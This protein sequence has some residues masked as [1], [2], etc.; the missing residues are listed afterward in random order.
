[1]TDD[2]KTFRKSD[3]WPMVATMLSATLVAAGIIA[4]D[5]VF[6]SLD[7]GTVRVAIIGALVLVAALALG[8]IDRS[9]AMRR[10]NLFR[11]SATPE[12]SA[13]WAAKLQEEI[14]AQSGLNPENSDRAKEAMSKVP[15]PIG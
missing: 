3:L 15:P 9:Q 10:E 5:A 13:R 7:G 4:F 14:D 1:M 11:S 2:K 8:A 6:G 12:A